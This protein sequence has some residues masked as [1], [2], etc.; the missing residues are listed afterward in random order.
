MNLEFGR[1]LRNFIWRFRRNLDMMIFHKF[2]SGSQGFLEN[3]LCH[4]MNASLG[5]INL[6]KSFL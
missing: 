3:K 5:Q 2:F 1:P 6:R 4:A